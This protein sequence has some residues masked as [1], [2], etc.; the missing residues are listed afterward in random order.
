MLG[1]YADSYVRDQKVSKLA[2]QYREALIEGRKVIPATDS[3]ENFEETAYQRVVDEF[4]K[5]KIFTF[6]DSLLICG[7]SDSKS[8]VSALPKDVVL[9]MLALKTLL[10]YPSYEEF[11]AK[12]FPKNELTCWL[13]MTTL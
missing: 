8:F 3:L 6:Q 2:S 7:L 12:L 1:L 5:N 11:G 13:R 10:T 4:F 9:H